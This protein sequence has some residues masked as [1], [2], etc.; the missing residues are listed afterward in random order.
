MKL[1]SIPTTSLVPL[2]RQQT[3][4]GGTS[5][6]QHLYVLLCRSKVTTLTKTFLTTFERTAERLL[7]ADGPDGQLKG[8]HLHSF[9][10]PLDHI[11]DLRDFKSIVVCKPAT[12]KPPTV[13]ADIHLFA[14]FV[15]YAHLTAE[16]EAALAAKASLLAAK[17]AQ[18]NEDFGREG[19]QVNLQHAELDIATLQAS[20]HELFRMFDRDRSDDRDNCLNLLEYELALKALGVQA[21]KQAMMKYFPSANRLITLHEFQRAWVALI[22]VVAECETRKL[23]PLPPPP[24]LHQRLLH[25]SLR[26]QQLQGHLLAGLAA[27]A[28]EEVAAAAAARDVVL[29][30]GRLRAI[31]RQTAQREVLH[32][33][34]GEEVEIKTMEALREREEKMQRRR[35][36]N[37]KVKLVQ[38]EKRL[39]A[40]VNAD[41]ER[42]KQLLMSVRT[43]ALMRRRDDTAARRAARGDDELLLANRQLVVVPHELYHG[44][45]ALME[46]SNMIIVDLAHNKLT[47]LPEN[48]AYNLDSVQKLDISY[49]ELES[50]PADIGQLHALRLLSV[51]RNRLTALPA[52]LSR[53]ACLEILDVSSNALCSLRLGHDTT[54]STASSWGGLRALQALYVGDNNLATLP[55]DLSATPSLAYLDMVGNPVSRFPLSFR[56][57]RALV[58]LDVSKC[59]LKHLSTEFGSHP[60][61]QVVQMSYNMLSHLPPSVAGL[62]AMQE[63]SISHNELLSLPDAVGAWGDLVALD[64]SYNRIRLL[65]DEIGQWRQ[66]EVLNLSHNRLQNVPRQIGSLAFL[67]TLHLRDNALVELPLD[68]GAL[69]ALRHCDLSRNALTALPPQLGFCHALRTLD[70]SENVITALPPSAGMWMAL[71]KLQLQHNQLVSPLPDT[72]VDWTALRVLDLSHN[73]LTH[74]DRALCTLTRLESLNVAKNRIAFLPVEVGNMTGLRH[75]DLYRNALQALPMELAMLIPTLEVLHVDGNPL[76]ALPEKWCTR[77]RLQDKYRT[78]F[79]H[80]YSTPEALEWTQDHAIY[81]P[82]VVAVWTAHADE[83]L[84]HAVLVSSFLDEVRTVLHDQ[85]QPRFEKPV[86][87]HFFEF[88]YQGHPTVYDDAGDDVRNDHRRQEAARAASRDAQ[89]AAIA[90]DTSVLA[91]ALDETY[92][93]NMVEAEMKSAVKRERHRR[94]KEFERHVAAKTLQQYIQ[95]HATERNDEEARR[96]QEARHEFAERMTHEALQQEAILQ[97]NYSAPDQT[98]WNFYHRTGRHLDDMMEMQ[99]EDGRVEKDHSRIES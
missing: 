64:A 26:T 95:V 8:C 65:P 45:A 87:M 67:H 79:A 7:L 43:E 54:N 31:E 30:I 93:V 49:N 74:L 78:Q 53:L 68:M 61:A 17:Q 63:L 76:S 10:H 75:L 97:R 80:G 96:R 81:Y 36:R 5:I 1:V 3:N 66:V 83:Y 42:R 2:E 24:P 34:R 50:L 55:P 70:V 39:V 82:A 60:R 92:A 9:D 94:K 48:F 28:A 20:A 46:L 57:C 32:L 62:T 27:Q 99:V 88:K 29:E 38:E 19:V 56:D 41:R 11:M 44:K 22:D 18:D 12:A 37:A 69:T 40:L 52:S 47:A 84:S 16:S 23:L 58:M 86:K 4:E 73:A 21:P 91:H 14:N 71:E 98:K 89:V 15:P 51:R 25:P 33:K 77:W 90:S 59:A 35:A 6:R 85:W 72:V 13:V